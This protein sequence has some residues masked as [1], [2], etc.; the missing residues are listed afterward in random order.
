[1]KHPLRNSSQGVHHPCDMG[2]WT[3]SGPHVDDDSSAGAPKGEPCVEPCRS[4]ERRETG[5]V[6]EDGK[7]DILDW[8]VGVGEKGWFDGVAAFGAGSRGE[9][10]WIV[11][12]WGG[13][14]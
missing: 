9:G 14:R 2:R 7:V 3:T 1:M 12:L 8:E 10:M 6:A 5:D 4:R 13:W 11:G